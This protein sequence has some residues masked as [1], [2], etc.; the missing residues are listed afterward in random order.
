MNFSPA[1]LLQEEF[2]MS[3][4]ALRRLF[5]GAKRSTTI[6]RPTARL[7]CASVSSLPEAADLTIAA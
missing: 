4:S 6:T 1:F 3:L 5:F 7:R 2:A